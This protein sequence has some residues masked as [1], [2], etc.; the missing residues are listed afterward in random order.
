[1]L[2]R[3]DVFTL[4]LGLASFQGEL[5]TQWHYLLAMTVV[6][7]VPV[8]VVFAF[9]QKYITSGIASSGMK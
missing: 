6:T 9:L 1:M 4:Q 8:S 7:L 2:N 3:E 5:Q